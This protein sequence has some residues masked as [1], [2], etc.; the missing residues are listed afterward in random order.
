VNGSDAYVVHMDFGNGSDSLAF[1]GA[2]TVTGFIDLGGGTDTLSQGPATF[3]P[4]V[5]IKNVP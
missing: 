3:L 4:P 2:A 1:T 5:T